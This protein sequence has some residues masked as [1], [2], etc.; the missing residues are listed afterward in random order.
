MLRREM[1]VGRRIPDFVFV[2]Y[3]V[4]PPEPLFRLRW[5][6]RH[7]SVVAELRRTTSLRRDTLADRLFERRSSL[8]RL[9]KDLCAVGAVHESEGGGVR[10]SAEIQALDTQVTAI[11]AKLFRWTEALAQAASYRA[12]ADR[13]IV[14]MDAQRVNGSAPIITKACRAAGVGVV[15]VTEATATYV[16]AGRRQLARTAQREY[17]CLSA[18]GSRSQTLWTRL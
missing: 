5:T 7:A 18:I 2:S 3:S 15:M 14:A 13:V 1:P 6:Y 9:L 17:V 16:H 8:D 4:P 12:F 11:E 10:L